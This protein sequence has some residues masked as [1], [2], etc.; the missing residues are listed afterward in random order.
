[1]RL[2]LVGELD[3]GSAGKLDEQLRELRTVR[4]RRFVVDLRRLTFIDSTGVH[5]I[6][7]ATTVAR[8][9]GIDLSLIQGP[10]SVERTFELCGLLGVLSFRA[11]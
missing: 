2:V 11:P 3:I 1:V 10:R 6:I 9:D 4:F 7:N 5:L 8:E